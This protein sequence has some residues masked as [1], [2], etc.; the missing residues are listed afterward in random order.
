MGVLALLRGTPKQVS[1]AEKI[2]AV[3]I[4]E[5]RRL[6][7]RGEIDQSNEWWIETLERDFDVATWW[8]ENRHTDPADFFSSQPEPCD[9][10]D[11]DAL[12]APWA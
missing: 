3:K 11:F 9:D 8:I 12:I 6:I 1:W 10:Q 7:L 5:M 4:S 2:R